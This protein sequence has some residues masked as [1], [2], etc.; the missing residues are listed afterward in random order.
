MTKARTENG[1]KK[2][3]LWLRPEAANILAETLARAR[4]VDKAMTQ[5]ELINDAIMRHYD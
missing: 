4:S 1:W 5:N 2:V 3:S